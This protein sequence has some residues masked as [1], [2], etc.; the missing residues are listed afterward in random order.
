MQTAA[1]PCCHVLPAHSPATALPHQRATATEFARI[2][3]PPRSS[4]PASH[5]PHS[6][7]SSLA[8]LSASPPISTS[9]TSSACRPQAPSA[10]PR[11]V[12]GVLHRAAAVRGA[13]D[14]DGQVRHVGQPGAAAAATRRRRSTST[15][16]RLLAGLRHAAGRGARGRHHSARVR[17]RHEQ[18]HRGVRGHPASCALCSS[19]S[20]DTA[21]TGATTG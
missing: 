4:S 6:P 18:R 14:L 1:P 15:A 16:F 8:Q 3:T 21:C 17:H 19:R 2:T 11:P 12:P 10:A 5:S 7:L 9:A 20:A 13:A